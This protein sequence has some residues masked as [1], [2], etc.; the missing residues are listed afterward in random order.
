MKKLKGFF[1]K[2]HGFLNKN[3][4]SDNSKI[5]EMMREIDILLL[6]TLAECSAIAFSEASGFGIPIFSHITWCWQLRY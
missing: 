3:K 6:P 5:I 4:N 1:V 2:Y